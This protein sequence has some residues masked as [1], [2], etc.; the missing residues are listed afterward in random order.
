MVFW[1]TALNDSSVGVGY[2]YVSHLDF[3]SGLSGIEEE[4]MSLSVFY[5]C[6][7]DSPH[8]C[9]SVDP[10]SCRLLPYASV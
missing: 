1:V 8:H 4:A 7:C 6:I 3:K 10:I 9:C 2:I 5:Y